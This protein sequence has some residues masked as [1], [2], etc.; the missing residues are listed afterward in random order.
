M[1]TIILAV[2]IGFV[3]SLGAGF[4]LIPVLRKLHAGQSIREDGPQSH[5][6]KAGTPTMGGIFITLGVLAAV[7]VFIGKVNVYI[8][9]ALICAVAFGLIGLIDDLIIVLKHRN[10]G[11]KVWQKFGA[12]FVFAVLIAIFAYNDS[13][14]GSRL[15]IP[16]A[17]TYWDLGIWYIPFTVFVILALTN[18]VNLTDGLDGLAGGVTLIDAATFG[19]IFLSMGTSKVW[20][21]DMMIFSAGLTGAILGFLRY[22]TYPAKVFMGDTGSLFLGGALSAIAIISRL[23][24]LIPF[25][26]LMYVASGLSCILQIGSFKLRHKRIF[27]MAPLHHHFELKGIHET[28]IVSMYMIITAIMCLLILLTFTA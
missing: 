25:I 1:Q 8:W 21:Q 24:I 7:L 27:K 3:V 11:L 6:S 10:L 9:V 17:N 14:I 20:S 28:K 16:I 5:L 26:G 23:Q 22:N 2:L 18:C 12:Q 4:L 15:F 19:I 13:E